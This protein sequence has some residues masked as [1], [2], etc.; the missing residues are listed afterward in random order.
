MATAKN[1]SE[2]PLSGLQPTKTYVGFRALILS[3]LVLII[4]GAGCMW[5]ESITGW[6]GEDE[7]FK[8]LTFE[9]KT[10]S[11]V[12]S[13]TED[14]N[15]E[16]G[17][18]IELKC[19]VKGGAEILNIVPDGTRIVAKGEKAAVASADESKKAVTAKEKKETSPPNAAVGTGDPGDGSEETT[20]EVGDVLVEL[21]RSSIDDALDTQKIVVSKAEAVMIQAEKDLAVATI[22]VREY[23]EGTYIQ[24]LQ[25]LDA[26]VTI[27]KE[28]LRGTENQFKHTQKMYRKGF[29][30]KLQLEADEFAVKRATLE[31]AAS[32]TK[33]KVLVNFTK[34]KMLEDLRSKVKTAQAKV[35]S[36]TQSLSLEKRKLSR[37]TE[38][39]NHCVILAESPGMAVYANQR[40]RYGRG[41]VEIEAGLVVRN[42]QPI[43]R[44]P[45]LDSMQ[46]KVRV[47]ES[48]VKQVQIGDK[49]TLKLH[50]REELLTGVV[51]AIAN[52]PEPTSWYQAN[53]QEYATTVKIDGKPTDL[54][55]GMSAEVVIEVERR[56]DVL[57][58]PVEA[59]VEQAGQYF[60]WVLDGGKLRSVGLVAAERREIQMARSQKGDN[61]VLT[62]NKFVGVDSGIEAGQVVVL[63]PRG[64]IPEAQEMVRKAKEEATSTTKM[65]SEKG[66]GLKG[67]GAASG[68][69]SYEKGKGGKKQAQRG[70]AGKGGKGKGGRGGGGQAPDAATIVMLYWPRMD[71]NK[72]GVLDEAEINVTTDPG[73]IRMADKNGDGKVTKAEYTAAIR[74]ALANGKKKRGEGS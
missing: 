22:S 29:V 37:L 3:L 20:V 60:C 72:D 27:A 63:N 46:V 9:V 64:V 67:G 55:P 53:V 48:K 65:E 19:K 12:V 32:N 39:I 73:R 30:T 13:V 43:I 34:Q 47:H 41:G 16:S 33:K 26:E 8:D 58:L 51:T 69:R 11:L 21:D 14:G 49:A 54:V 24:D 6:G 70:P 56:E 25:L 62:D 57:R 4:C 66:M 44:I 17:N 10:G 45:D 28:N 52:Q 18:P 5:I 71:T 59:V 36:E 68:A 35:F 61:R 74:K 2:Q 50:G 23:E 42:K 15:V 31:L 40:P 1:G 38:Q 7:E